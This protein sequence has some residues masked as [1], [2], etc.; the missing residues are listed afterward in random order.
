MRG[1]HELPWGEVFPL[2]GGYGREWSLEV[3]EKENFA[4]EMPSFDIHPVSLA[5]Q[6]C[7]STLCNLKGSK[8]WSWDSKKINVFQLVCMV[9]LQVSHWA[10][11][12]LKH[13]VAEALKV[14]NISR[15]LWVEPLES[16]AKGTSCVSCKDLLLLG[17]LSKIPFHLRDPKASLQRLLWHPKLSSYL[18]VSPGCVL[19]F[20][21]KSR[22]SFS[23]IKSK[24]L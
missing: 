13:Y 9:T 19:F 4:W 6:Q 16:T 7:F 24:E 22:F 18:I 20:H 10:W 17:V 8:M 3:K 14:L 5:N 23:F 2:E 11:L 15:Q 21:S 1:A 12:L